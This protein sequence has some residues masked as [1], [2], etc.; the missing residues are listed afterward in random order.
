[1]VC[2]NVRVIRIGFKRG[3]GRPLERERERHS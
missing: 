1:M 3:R 2:S